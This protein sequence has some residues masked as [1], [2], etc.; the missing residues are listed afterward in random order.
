LRIGVIEECLLGVINGKGEASSVNC[1]IDADRGLEMNEEAKEA[2]SEG[3]D[4]S[5]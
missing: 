3:K 5:D 2:E 1:K 4:R